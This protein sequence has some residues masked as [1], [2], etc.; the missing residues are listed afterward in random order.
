MTSMKPGDQAKVIVMSFVSI[1]VMII[2]ITTVSIMTNNM[3]G[4][5]HA[6]AGE[7][8]ESSE[9]HE[10]MA[11]E[12]TEA[13][14]EEKTEEAAPATE[15]KAEE[16]KAEEKPAEAKKPEETKEAAKPAEAKKAEGDVAAGQKVFVSKTC[17]TCHT[18]KKVPE[19]KGTIGPDL[20]GLYARAGSRKPGTS[21]DDYIKESIENPTAFVVAG[22]QP[23]MPPLRSTMSDQEYKDLQAFLHSL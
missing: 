21:A 22:F 5:E 18:V 1:I 15:H 10:K 6:E 13:K 14:T 3:L 4:S 12:K 9:G 8:A 7:H 11:E 17:T 19:A 2:V 20:D 23:A 16:K